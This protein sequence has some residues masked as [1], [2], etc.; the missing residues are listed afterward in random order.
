MWDD[1]HNCCDQARYQIASDALRLFK[2]LDMD[3]WKVN[4]GPYLEESGGIST[5]TEKTKGTFRGAQL[6]CTFLDLVVNSFKVWALDTITLKSLIRDVLINEIR[7]ARQ[8][9]PVQAMTASAADRVFPSSP[10]TSDGFPP[11]FKPWQVT[12]RTMEKLDKVQSAIPVVRTAGK[13]KG[14]KRSKG[15]RPRH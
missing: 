1:Y 6:A 5:S 11:T 15:I 3:D 12:F 9:Q 10:V 4:W 14:K 13:R 8:H 2:E 7:K